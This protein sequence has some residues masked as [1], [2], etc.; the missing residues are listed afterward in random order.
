MQMQSLKKLGLALTLLLLLLAISAVESKRWR[1]YHKINMRRRKGHNALGTLKLNNTSVQGNVNNLMISE[2]KETVSA[3]LP[4]ANLS[5]FYNNVYTVALDFGSNGQPLTVLVDTGSANLAVTSSQCKQ[6]ICLQRNSY[7]SGKSKTYKQNG[8]AI[9][10]DYVDGTLK[11]FVS[12]DTVELDGLKVKNQD[13]AEVTSLPN[14][15]SRLN[16]IDGIWGLGFIDIAIDGAVPLFYNLISQKLIDIPIFSVYLNRNASDPNNGGQLLL[17]G[18]DPILYKGCLTYVPILNT[19]YWQIPVA[20]F[21]LGTTIL[22]SKFDAIVDIGTSLI[23][24]PSNAI[25]IINQKLQIKEFAAKDGVYIVPCNKV[26]SLSDITVN[27]GRKDFTLK[28]SDYILNY[29]GTCVSAFTNCNG[30]QGLS[31][32]WVFG[33]AF[34]APFYLEFDFEYKRIGIAPKL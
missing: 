8:T 10:I 26:S 24:V 23:C 15:F 33:D 5:N 22:F 14:A 18:S 28:P 21:T 20:R 16:G 29:N 2:S 13:F 30:L 7:N 27:I 19:G 11:G 12:R 32:L 17:G 6:Q 34:I 31:N 1:K 4:T 9:Q 3:A 25:G